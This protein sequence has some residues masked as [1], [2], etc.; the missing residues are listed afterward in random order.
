MTGVIFSS[1]DQDGRVSGE[2][3]RQIYFS[4]SIESVSIDCFQAP[5]VM[6]SQ[7]GVIGAFVREAQM[8]RPE[9]GTLNVCDP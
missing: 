1:P 5:Y 4:K 2:K 9:A 3:R 8:S 6:L 7:S